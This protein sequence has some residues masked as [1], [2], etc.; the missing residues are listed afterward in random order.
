MARW[1]GPGW[2]EA[3]GP[4]VWLSLGAVWQRGTPALAL[5]S[6][7]P[8][9]A[10]SSVGKGQTG[11]HQPPSTAPKLRGTSQVLSFFPKNSPSKHIQKESPS[12]IC[13]LHLSPPKG[14]P[15]FSLATIPVVATGHWKT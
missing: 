10:G 15:S 7:F 3:G 14:P 11:P 2:T 4:E 8:R 6:Q 1:G 9:P 5:Q 12:P 13:Q